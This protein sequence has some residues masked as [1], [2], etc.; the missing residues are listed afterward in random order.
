MRWGQCCFQFPVLIR[1]KLFLFV[2][3]TADVLLHI[4]K[5]FNTEIILHKTTFAASHKSKDK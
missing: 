3:Y 1:G 2:Y 4:P 5:M